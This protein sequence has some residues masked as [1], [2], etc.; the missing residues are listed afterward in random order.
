MS[1]NYLNSIPLH[2]QLKEI[3]KNR[4][5]DGKYVNRIPSEKN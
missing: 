5:I 2:E 1:L 4:I 3:I